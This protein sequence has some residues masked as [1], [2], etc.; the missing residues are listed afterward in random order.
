MK[1]LGLKGR[2]PARQFRREKRVSLILTSP[3]VPT[4]YTDRPV[5]GN[6]L[7]RCV[8]HRLHVSSLTQE[9]MQHEQIV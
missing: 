6:E 9:S 7:L 5:L 8:V 4:G 3:P 2:K 1:N